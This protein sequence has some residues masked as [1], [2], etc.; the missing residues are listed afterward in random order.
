MIN[1]IKAFFRLFSFAK[2]S[3][4]PTPVPVDIVSDLSI[5][6]NREQIAKIIFEIK[7]FGMES[8]EKQQLWAEVVQQ[9]NAIP[10]EKVAEA[11]E[12]AERAQNAYSKVDP[13]DFS[14]FDGLMNHIQAN[15]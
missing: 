10:A 11:L 9:V 7:S 3:K 12:Q 13:R 6:L 4:K 5:R 1:V 2:R 8:W 14:R 15:Q